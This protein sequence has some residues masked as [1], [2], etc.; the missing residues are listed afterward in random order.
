MKDLSTAAPRP[1]DK[2]AEQVDPEINQNEGNRHQQEAKNRTFREEARA[3]LDRLAFTPFED[4]QPLSRDFEDVP[5]KVGL[6]AFRHRT[7]ELL[8]IGK[9]KSLRDRLRGGHRLFL[10]GWLDRYNPDD[11]RIAFVTIN[12]WRK[13][14]LSYEPR[15][16]DSP[17]DSSTL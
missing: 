3:I 6:Y 4:C 5:G 8:Y 15:D 14:G 16:V 7:E 1:P 10:W 17:G 11:V 12:Q 13:P 9:A 2:V